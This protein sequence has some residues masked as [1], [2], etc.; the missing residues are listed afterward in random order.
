M[1][2]AIGK[3]YTT[4]GS[5]VLVGD[6][7]TSGLGLTPPAGMG[8]QVTKGCLDAWQYQQSSRSLAVMSYNKGLPGQTTPQMIAGIN[9]QVAPYY[10]AGAK[11]TW[12]ATTGN[13]AVLESGINDLYNGASAAT[14]EADQ[15]TWLTTVRAL[16]FK[17]V[18]QTITPCQSVG[19]PGGYEANR[20]SVNSYFRAH[21]ELYDAISDAGAL[22]QAQD[23]TNATYY[24]ADK[25]HYTAVLANL[26]AVNCTVPAI[27]SL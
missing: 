23:P 6:S 11:F 16:G 19:T 3:P 14:V 15:T 24:Q 13:V 4:V 12:L 17:V 25:V 26:I 27:L 18:Y 10:V 2:S 5:L 22:S 21:P 20:L 8:D 1:I 7:E 9:I